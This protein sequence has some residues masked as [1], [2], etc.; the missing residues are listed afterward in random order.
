MKKLLTLLVISALVLGTA[1]LAF[2]QPPS[3]NDGAKIRGDILKEI[4]MENDSYAETGYT[5]AAGN[6]AVTAVDSK[7]ESKASE[8]ASDACNEAKEA[9]VNQ[10]VADAFSGNATA[11]NYPDNLDKEDIFLKARATSD[12]DI[13]V[14][15]DLSVD[16]KFKHGEIFALGKG[17]DGKGFLNFCDCCDCCPAEIQGDIS[18]FAGFFNFAT[19]ITGGAEALGNA[20]VTAIS[21]HSKAEAKDGGD[22][23]NK[24]NI[25]VMNT[26]V[27]TAVSG[28]AVANNYP[29]NTVCIDIDKIAESDKDVNVDIDIC[30]ELLSR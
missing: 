23:T 28:E 17:K 10:G 5:S 3:A 29:D 14:D 16:K 6:T 9:V 21:S 22:A 8:E 27:G 19:A 4:V 11:N 25:T 7:S 20:S 18:I 30:A 24:S 13:D 1:G 26:G 12:C 2:A 15:V